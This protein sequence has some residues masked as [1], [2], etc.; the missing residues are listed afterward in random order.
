M[1]QDLYNNAD[2][3]LK[4]QGASWYREAGER[5]AQLAAEHG[6]SV[7][8]AA[9][10]V[11]A[12]SP[13]MPW[14]SNLRLAGLVLAGQRHG[15]LQASLDKAS[16]IIEGADPLVVLSGPKTNAFYRALI[17]DFDAVV[18]DVWM[19]RALGHNKNAC[20]PR[21]YEVFADTIR[22][23]ALEAGETPAD[24]QAIVWC[25]IRGKAE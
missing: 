15:C 10:V 20:T 17:G 23:A 18:V 4:A 12:L 1:L 21:Q 7:Q 9:G 25:A 3:S 2:T 5:C 13:R 24:F 16:K 6:T 8:I 11:A 22:N 19:L 14:S